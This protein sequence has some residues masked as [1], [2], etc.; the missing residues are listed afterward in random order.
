[1]LHAKSFDGS[2]TGKN[3]AETFED[4]FQSWVID[5]EGQAHLVVCDNTSNM[6]RV[7]SIASL[8]DLGCFVHTQQ[9]VVNDGVLSQRAVI[10]M[11]TTARKVVG[12]FQHSCQGY[13][14]LKNI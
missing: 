4:T 7:M 14:H 5:K 11:L 3:I 9:L 12:H 8:T 13:D 1:M 10:D 2:H 6:I